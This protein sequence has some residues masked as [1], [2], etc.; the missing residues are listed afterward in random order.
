VLIRLWEKYTQR[1]IDIKIT[2]R[3]RG[4]LDYFA[5]ELINLM[6]DQEDEAYESDDSDGKIPKT[7]LEIIEQ[8]QREEELALWDRR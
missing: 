3:A 5:K 6:R 7:V 2:I 8:L 1:K 4:K